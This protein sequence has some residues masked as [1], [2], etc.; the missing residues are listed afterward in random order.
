[1]LAI[2]SAFVLSLQ[3]QNKKIVQVSGYILAEGTD[4][5]VPFVTMSFDLEAKVAT[6]LLR[7]GQSFLLPGQTHSR[8]CPR[9]EG[10]ALP[11]R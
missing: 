11:L 9:M 8:A 10:E 3:A 5:A 4:I 6:G 1:M 7:K 2:L